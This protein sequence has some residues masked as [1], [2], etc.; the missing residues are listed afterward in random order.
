MN[1][2]QTIFPFY[3]RSIPLTL[4]VDSEG[5]CKCVS[6]QKL[7]LFCVRVKQ[8][9][10]H[11]EMEVDDGVTHAIMYQIVVLYDFMIVNERCD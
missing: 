5:K 8:A 6:K 1:A 9:I 7:T 2:W 3:F 11:L 10:K 4:D